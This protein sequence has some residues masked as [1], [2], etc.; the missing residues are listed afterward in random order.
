MATAVTGAARRRTRRWA[1]VAALLA[2]AAGLGC[3]LL[4]RGPAVPPEAEGEA[5]LAGFADRLA[6]PDT[7][8]ARGP[9]ALALFPGLG[10]W[11]TGSCV[12]T[13]SKRKPSAP[14]VTYQR[15]ELGRLRPDEPCEQA[16]FGML[17]TT[18]RQSEGVTPGALAALFT[19]RFGP[20]AIHR[21][22]SLR[23]AILE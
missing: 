17:S 20:P 10:T 2:A 1:A 4:L 5:W 9:A 3:V 7:W 18:L 12:L 21:D 22:T 19:D 11:S 6:A 23:G 16:Q 14:V 13:W 8:S 15:L